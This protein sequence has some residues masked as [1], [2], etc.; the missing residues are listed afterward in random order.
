MK[1]FKRKCGTL[2]CKCL[3]SAEP[4]VDKRVTVGPIVKPKP[5]VRQPMAMS[6]EIPVKPTPSV[7]QVQLVHQDAVRHPGVTLV[8]NDQCREFIL[9][10]SVRSCE[11]FIPI[12]KNSPTD[13]SDG[14]IRDN[15]INHSI[16]ITVDDNNRLPQHSTETS[17]DDP[18]SYL[19]TRW[20]LNQQ[21]L[22]ENKCRRI[23]E[24]FTGKDFPKTTLDFVDAT[25]KNVEIDCYCEDLK[26]GIDYD[27][28]HKY[29]YNSNLQVIDYTALSKIAACAENNVE[30]I[31]V[32]YKLDR[33]DIE[34]YL[35]KK[36]KF[37]KEPGK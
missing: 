23:A 34:C 26:L 9:D 19:E 17:D 32:P 8:N 27:G 3:E 16:E 22:G 37:L 4:A 11:Q 24:S 14:D 31:I 18:D 2:F 15:K 21:M 30:L 33:K 28:L 25:G 20:C 29:E 5:V 35:E 7:K 36:R 10:E 12:R 1:A 13:S 6:R